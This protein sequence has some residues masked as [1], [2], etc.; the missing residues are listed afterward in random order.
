MLTSQKSL[1]SLLLIYVVQSGRLMRDLLAILVC[2]HHGWSVLRS[3]MF[4]NVLHLFFR[5]DDLLYLSFQIRF[6]KLHKT[7]G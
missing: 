2:K 7:H 4:A 5:G 3:F 6:S 1:H